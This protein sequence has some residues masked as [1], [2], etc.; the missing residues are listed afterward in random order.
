MEE[1]IRDFLLGTGIIKR[2]FKMKKVLKIL[3]III[4]TAVIGFPMVSCGDDSIVSII[5]VPFELTGLDGYDGKY[6]VAWGNNDTVVALN[7]MKD[8]GVQVNNGKA[9]LSVWNAGDDGRPTTEYK[10]NDTVLFWVIISE[11]TNVNFADGSDGGDG[12]WAIGTFKNGAGIGTFTDKLS[13]IIDTIPDLKSGIL[14]L[15]GLDDYEGSYVAALGGDDTL[16]LVAAKNVNAQAG[17]G[18]GVKIKNGKAV[19][20]VW[21]AEGNESS[22]T[23]SPYNGNGTVSF[24]VGIFNNANVNFNN[25]FEDGKGGMALATFQ[26]GIGAGYF[27]INPDELPKPPPTGGKT[28][29]DITVP[30]NL[31]GTW[32]GEDGTLEFV[33]AS[34]STTDT[35]TK[36]YAFI[37]AIKKANTETR[38]VTINSNNDGK[39]GTISTLVDGFAIVY[40]YSWEIN[41]TT[42][43][44]TDSL[45]NK[46]VFTGTKQQP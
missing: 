33:K 7:L 29:V 17:T 22:H 24:S 3:G 34:I 8:K 30:D 9:L 20:N 42:L 2:S 19:L 13:G 27:Y 40:L 31:L 37:V 26:K 46:T 39:K 45:Y 15:T 38:P 11:N 41:D 44:I 21:K 23:V 6:I 35:T 43:K 25:G 4:L 16:M 10:A 32:E 28:S 14:T 12:G 36:A 1:N 18:K 5:G